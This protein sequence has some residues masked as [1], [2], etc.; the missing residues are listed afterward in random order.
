MALL[1]PF[2]HTNISKEAP[3]S[4]TASLAKTIQTRSSYYNF[5]TL[6]WHCWK[7]LKIKVTHL[8]LLSQAK[9]MWTCKK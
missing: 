2:L 7:A 1:M 8:F 3:L 5:D 9:C 4:I 6:H